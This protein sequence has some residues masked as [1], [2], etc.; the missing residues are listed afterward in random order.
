MDFKRFVIAAG[1]AQQLRHLKERAEATA[2]ALAIRTMTGVIAGALLFI[3]IVFVAL[4]AFLWLSET[5][6]PQ[7]AALWVAGGFV[8]LALI[9]W[10]AGSAAANRRRHRVPAQAGSPLAGL[11]AAEDTALRQGRE[12]GARLQERMSRNPGKTVAIG[13]AA[14]LALGLAP[15][16]GRLLSRRRD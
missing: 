2:Q 9:L 1:A 8:V 15:S 14:G 7:V 11:A 12:I 16:V 6:A 4:A 5:M 13:L 3:A 10:I